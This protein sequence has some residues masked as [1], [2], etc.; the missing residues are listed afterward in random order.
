MILQL[1]TKTPYNIK[2]YM[3]FSVSNLGYGFLFNG[4][5]SDDETNGEGNIINYDARIFNTRIGR[6]L[7][8]DPLTSKFPML[9]P[10]Q[11]A[12]NTPIWGVDLDGQEVT[13]YTESGN[14]IKG[15]VGHTFISI[16]TG[17]NIV[18]Y[19]YGRYDCKLPILPT[20]QK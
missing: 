10:Y 2:P 20:I 9:T 18:V 4:K 15:N 16:G 8:V 14:F 17:D 13:L 12:S 3:D 1:N 7:S 5:E 11:F 6:F 19:T